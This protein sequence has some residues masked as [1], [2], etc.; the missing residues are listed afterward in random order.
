VDPNV[1]NALQRE[2]RVLQH[3]LQQIE[4]RLEKELKTSLLPEGPS[5]KPDT[6]MEHFVSPS[7]KSAKVENFEYLE[8]GHL[9]SRQP[10]GQKPVQ[11]DTQSTS[12][13]LG[14]VAA[15][16]FVLAGSFLIKLAIDAGWLTPQRQ[17]GLTFVLGISLIG[18]GF[19]L[20][21][22]DVDYAAILPAVGVVILYTASFAG[23]L[24]YDLYDP[25]VAMMLA[26]GVSLLTV[27]LYRAFES[28]FYCLLAVIGSY[29]S[30]LLFPSFRDTPWNLMIFF[31]GWDL[32]FVTI[33]VWIKNR[34]MILLAS[35][36]A[37]GIFGWL[38]LVVYS[39]G[40]STFFAQI[41]GFE[42]IQFMIFAA[43]LVIYS[44]GNRKTLSTGEAWAYLPL[45]LFF[46]GI[47]YSVLSRIWQN[48]APWLGLGF[49]ALIYI[50]YKLTEQT[51]KQAQ[52][53]SG[54]MVSTFISI[55][56]FHSF[57]LE[58]LPDRWAPWFALILLMSLPLLLSRPGLIERHAVASLAVFLVIA[59]NYIRTLLELG[60]RISITEL[61]AINIGFFTLLI[62]G[63]LFRPKEERSQGDRWM[64]I[65][66]L[67]HVQAMIGLNR[68]ATQW[69]QYSST[70][71]Y[72][73]FITSILWSLLAVAVLVW[74]MVRKERHL[75]QSA[76][77]VFA[78][79]AGKIL[80]IDVSA[81]RALIRVI[82]LLILGALFYLGGYLYRHVNMWRKAEEA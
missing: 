39:K 32:T 74:G 5:L 4:E 65:L 14:C 43:S 8:R 3:K 33:S 63:Y 42:F 68:L 72:S 17:L 50:F 16:C 21:K 10:S 31:L 24:Y 47:E 51:A 55:V 11:K 13:F 70:P 60:V 77:F 64:P 9:E 36:L 81:S 26:G 69:F 61:I 41:A 20:Q 66:I 82:S 78:I 25:T 62:T 54:A 80:L 79:S 44:I 2:L 35:Y 29:I 12:K 59:L 46:Y 19:L 52:L 71:V 27:W 18:A 75:A 73:R 76:L 45:L 57:Y 28:E 37:I 23:K 34:V 38:T 30:P 15:I 6:S 53:Q 40:G 58:I 67:A 49:A 1:L 22:R 48:I 56:L 7:A